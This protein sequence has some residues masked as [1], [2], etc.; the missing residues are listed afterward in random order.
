MSDTP[1]VSEIEVMLDI[2]H[3]LEAQEDQAGALVREVSEE[4][5]LTVRPV[6]K[7]S[8]CTAAS[9]SHKL[10][11]WLAEWVSGELRLDHEMSLTPAGLV[12]TRFF[13]LREPLT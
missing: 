2:G 8:E 9:G 7:V 3:R 11:W 10:H 5:G 6:R 1:Q 13:A 4:V 12:W